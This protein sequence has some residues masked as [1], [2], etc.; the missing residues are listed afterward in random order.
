MMK[1]AVI[2]LPKDKRKNLE[3][4]KREVTYHTQEIINEISRFLIR[5]IGG[6]KAVGRYIQMLKEK[7]KNKKPINLKNPLCS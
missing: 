1:H 2:K 4:S 3:S 6:Q 5:N 7:T